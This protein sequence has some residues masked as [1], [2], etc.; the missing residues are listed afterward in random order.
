M[1]E[2]RRR[3]RPPSGGR[4]AILEATMDL[5]RERGVARLTTRDVAER[6]GVSEASVYYHYTDKVGLLRAVFAAGLQPLE[7]LAYDEHASL[8]E[9]G[10]GLERFLDQALLVMM[11]AQS[12]VDLRTELAGFLAANDLGPH[13]GIDA[14][15]AR[16]DDA[17]PEAAAMLFIGASFLRV[18]QRHI[19]GKAAGRLPSLERTVAAFERLL[20][21]GAQVVPQL[22]VRRGAEAV[23]FYKAA[24]GAVEVFRFGDEDV[25]AQ[26]EVEGSPFWVETES[27]EHGN[28]SPET[29]GGATTRLLLL[30][31]D[32]DALMA[33]AVAAGARAVHPVQ[34]EHGW[35]L[36]R[37]EDPFG[38]HWEIGKPLAEWPPPSM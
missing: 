11:A 1:A 38:H 10:Q 34:E 32:P 17:D 15:G 24:F 8:L 26:L 22:S 16:L 29:V 31:A 13:R 3:G 18:A 28:Y 2:P 4:E 6:A 33:R 9:L 27:P 23:A 36:G 21:M 35:R 14:V 7:A 37:V 30:V 20:G 12:D 19:M 25:V 5:L